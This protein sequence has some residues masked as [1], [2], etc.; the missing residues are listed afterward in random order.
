MGEACFIAPGGMDSPEL[1]AQFAELFAQFA[2]L[3]TQFSQLC[4]QLFN[5]L[6]VQL[7][8]SWQF[9]ANSL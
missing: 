9:L 1:L 6:F 8:S 7:V 5:C 4:A 3:L 2:Q